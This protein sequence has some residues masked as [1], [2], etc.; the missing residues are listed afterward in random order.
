MSMQDFQSKENN[1]ADMV[2]QLQQFCDTYN[3]SYEYGMDDFTVKLPG[4]EPIPLPGVTKQ[5]RR[6]FNTDNW[7]PAGLNED[8]PD[9]PEQYKITEGE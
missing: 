9:D 7:G 2:E 3:L 8:D 4:A 6:T 1:R 5:K